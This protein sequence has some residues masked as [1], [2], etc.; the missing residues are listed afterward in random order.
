MPKQSSA[1][2]YVQVFAQR[3]YTVGCLQI[4]ILT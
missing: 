2:E 1:E 3:N 4:T